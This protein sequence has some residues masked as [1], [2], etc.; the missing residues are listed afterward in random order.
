M[1]VWCI[2][3]HNK[4]PLRPFLKEEKIRNRNEILPLIISFLN[5]TKD[6]SLRKKK[7]KNR[8]IIPFLEYEY[9]LYRYFTYDDMAEKNIFLIQ[10]KWANSGIF[11]ISNL[12]G[13]DC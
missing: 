13:L 9:T 2:Y 8:R 3:G 10:S 6:Q 11:L 12:T 7:I 1:V 5:G 4:F